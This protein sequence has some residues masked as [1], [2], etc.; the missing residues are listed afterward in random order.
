MHDQRRRS[1]AFDVG[2]HRG[3]H[4]AQVGDLGLA[5]RV[6][7]DRRALRVHCRREDVL[8]RPD[9]GE[10]EGD[11]GAAQPISRCLDV[12]VLQFERGTH[13]FETFD[14]HVDRT[15]AEVVTAG[16]RQRDAAAATQQRTEHVDRRPDPLHEL[17]RGD[18]GDVT[19]VDHGQ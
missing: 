12:A 14:V 3:Q 6:V 17:V 10:L 18:R 11:I 9:T 4:R 1:G 13:R 15:A 7:D 19:T 8:R 16:Q 5:R 2:A